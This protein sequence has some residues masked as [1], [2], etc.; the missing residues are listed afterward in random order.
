MAAPELLGIDNVLFGVGNLDAAVRFY[1]S[2][3]FVL[4]FRQDNAG[5]ALFSIGGE[6]PGLL[7]RAGGEGAVGGGRVW[8]EVR[9]ADA[10]A[11][12]LKASGIAT[13]RLETATG[14]T[15]E[16]KDPSG[17]IVGFADYSK[18]PDMARM[19]EDDVSSP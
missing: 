2:C 17:N 18:R 3:G 13:T 11:A 6:E 4:K 16:A 9:N 8:V 12:R 1:Q 7:V 5:M 19:I 14:I 15:V 10:A